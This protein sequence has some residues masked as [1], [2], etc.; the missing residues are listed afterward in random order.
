MLIGLTLTRRTNLAP[1]CWSR[2]VGHGLCR[3]NS[4]PGA[5]GKRVIHS[6]PAVSKGFFARRLKIQV[7]LQADGFAR[8]K[9]REGAI[10]VT[11]CLSWRLR[12]SGVSF[13]NTMKDL[14]NAFGSVARHSFYEVVENCAE[15]ADWILCKARYEDGVIEMKADEGIF[16]MRP[17]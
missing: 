15:Y 4:K 5:L 8:R 2:S 9:R 1:L 13:A 14:S 6:L 10:L 17:K 16:H 3:G 7:P 11:Q 12:R